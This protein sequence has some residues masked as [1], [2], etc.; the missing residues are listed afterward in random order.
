MSAPASNQSPELTTYHLLI[1]HPQEN[2]VL[3]VRDDTNALSLPS[4]DYPADE[5]LPSETA[6]I[7]ATLQSRFGNRCVLLHE[8]TA[9]PPCVIEAESLDAPDS[10]QWIDARDLPDQWQS[11]AHKPMHPLR[12]PW[13]QRGFFRCATEWTVDQLKRL[14]V[15]P[16]GEPVQVKGVWGY[17]TVI[18]FATSIG[19]VYFKAVSALQSNEPVLLKELAKRWPQNVP[20]V[21][22]SDDDRRWMLMRDF[23]GTETAKLPDDHHARCARRFA[24]IQI[25][26]ALDLARWQKATCAHRSL[27]FIASSID[28]LLAH[29]VIVQGLTRNERDRLAEISVLYKSLFARLSDFSLPDTLVNQDFRIGNIVWTNDDYV[30]YDWADSVVTHPFFSATRFLNY[31]HDDPHDPARDAKTRHQPIIDAYLDAWRAVLPTTQLRE[32]FAIARR[33]NAMYQAVRFELAMRASE[34]MIGWERCLLAQVK[35][36]LINEAVREGATTC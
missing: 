8:V 27:A 17:S 22:A 2:A 36:V 20:Q 34:P 5:W 21:I 18:R 31:I 28:V 13:E 32:A 23:G 15:E 11:A 10:V 14:N 25:D 16:S 4:M 3:V 30:F 24:E 6:P 29:P 26:A 1:R 35:D 33:I 9:E 19:N 12:A 7:T